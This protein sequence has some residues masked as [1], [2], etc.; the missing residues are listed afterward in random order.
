MAPVGN[1]GEEASEYI[2]KLND[3]IYGLSKIYA[4]SLPGDDLHSA[5]NVM[6]F[7]TSLEPLLKINYDEEGMQQFLNTRLNGFHHTHVYAS[8]M[9]KTIRMFRYRFECME[10]ADRYVNFLH[11][12]RPQGE[13]CRQFDVKEYFRSQTR[14]GPI[15]VCNDEYKVS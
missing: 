11:Q 10:M 3:K 13:S 4:R 14:P 2:K 9:K 12:P 8:D 5:P 7:Y 6:H 1:D 15:L